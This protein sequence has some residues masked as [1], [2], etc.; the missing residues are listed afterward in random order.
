MNTDRPRFQ[1]EPRFRWPEGFR[2]AVMLCFDVDGETTALSEDPALA[3]RPTLMSQCSYGPRI[4]VPRLLGLLAHLDV[5]ATFFI[6]AYVAEH[7]P[8]M[9]EAIAAGGHE[10]GLHGYLHEKLAYLTEAEEEAILVRSMEILTRLTGKTPVGYRAPWFETNPWTA[11]LLE[12]HGLLYG[13]SEMGDDV[14][15]L[16]P[17]GLL[18]IP[19]QWMLEDWEQFAFNADP[20]WGV[21]P[22]NCEKVYDLWWREFAA[23]HDFGCC[24]VLTLHPWLSGRP[25]RVRLLEDLV[26]AMQERGGVW[27]AR[28]AE[29]ATWVKDHP[30]GRRE[31]DL[32]YPN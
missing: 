25:S 28:G 31:L 7:H 21:V 24:F 15:Y 12:R 30:E 5:P 16:H 23:M 4:G 20:A 22:E 3:R 19:G 27:F 14:P 8:R 13:A 6:P 2:C 11:G 10:I 18:E 32:D 17:G 29:I 26:R 9:V 1:P